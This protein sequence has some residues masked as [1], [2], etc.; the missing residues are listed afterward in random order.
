MNSQY[1][2]LTI[3][4]CAILMIFPSP[5]FAQELAGSVTAESFEGRS[6]HLYCAG[7]KG[8]TATVLIDGGAAHSSVHYE[9]LVRS[10]GTEFHV[11][12]FDRP[13][14]GESSSGLFPRT[15]ERNGT[16]IAFLIEA[17]EIKTP[18]ILVGHSL[19]GLNALSFASHFSELVAGLVLVDSAH[20]EQYE[21]FPPSLKAAKDQTARAYWKHAALVSI[22]KQVGAE[23]DDSHRGYT[24]LMAEKIKN[25]IRHSG[26]SR[27]AAIASELE[28]VDSAAEHFR[29]S[30][31]KPLDVPLV[32]LT[33]KRSLTWFL[34]QDT[35]NDQIKPL[36]LLWE[37]LQKNLMDYSTDSV[38]LT[39]SGH[40]AL[41]ISD[42]ESIRRAIRVA[43]DKSGLDIA[44]RDSVFQH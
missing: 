36:Q 35:S 30:F 7:V 41:Q 24:G 21:R 11:C 10:L 28:S 25:E 42:P 22:E 17:A 40:H 15:P 43:V 33:A 1:K 19:G 2:Y 9:E 3:L 39:S 13:G 6:F 8:D 31:K 38:Q 12:V 14:Y 37:Q 16:D 26:P 32:V 20:P 23:L 18:I 4:V 27:F 44:G 5:V 34:Q 29:K